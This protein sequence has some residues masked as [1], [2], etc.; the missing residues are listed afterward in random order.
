M[1]SATV[2]HSGVRNM[3]TVT[4]LDVERLEAF[5]ASFSGSV[6]LPSHDRYEEAR[7]AIRPRATAAPHRRFAHVAKR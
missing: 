1:K 6:I 4:N 5:S 7:K 3:A 2:T